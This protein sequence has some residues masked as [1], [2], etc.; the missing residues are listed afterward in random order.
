MLESIS[1]N[2]EGCLYCLPSFTLLPLADVHFYTIDSTTSYNTLISWKFQTAWW[3][4]IAS[5]TFSEYWIEVYLVYLK[6]NGEESM[7][8]FL[9][10]LQPLLFCIQY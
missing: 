6:L 8:E 5:V 4:L 3:T 7:Q 1:K 2:N 9:K 10:N